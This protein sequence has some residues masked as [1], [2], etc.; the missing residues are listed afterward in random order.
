MAGNYDKSGENNPNYKGGIS[1]IYSLEDILSFGQE[2]VESVKSKLLTKIKICDKTQCWNWT[3]NIFQR[4]KRPRMSVG[5]TS[6]LT[7]RVSWLVYNLNDPKELLVCHHCDNILCI[8]PEHLYLGTNQ[9]NSNDMVARGRQADQRGGKN[10][11]AA[12]TDAQ[13]KE[14]KIILKT[15]KKV[16][17]RHL[18]KKYN[19]HFS[20]ISAINTGRIWGWLIV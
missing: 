13:A 10:P 20:T 2:F 4:S 18:A 6:F 3:G 9:D 11:Y 14:I 1:Q 16:V 7:S 5:V 12:L 15:D 17:Q 8:N 19:V